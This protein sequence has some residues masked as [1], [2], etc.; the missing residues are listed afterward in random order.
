MYLHHSEDD[1]HYQLPTDRIPAILHR[2]DRQPGNKPHL[3]NTN[4]TFWIRWTETLSA[5]CFSEH[6]NAWIEVT[7]KLNTQT[8][9][10][11]GNLMHTLDYTNTLT[12][13]MS[14]D[15]L[16]NTLLVSSDSG[17][18]CLDIHHGYSMDCLSI[19]IVLAAASMITGFATKVSITN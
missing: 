17:N 11:Q 12:F 18:L 14:E 10:N 13:R 9:L 1:P 19:L 16:L 2:V 6:Q 4:I 3:P 5:Y 8:Q 7:T 15:N